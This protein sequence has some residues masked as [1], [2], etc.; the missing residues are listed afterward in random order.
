MK[1]DTAVASGILNCDKCQLATLRSGS[2]VPA[3]PGANYQKG[4]IA[5]YLDGP[6]AAAEKAGKPLTDRLGRMVDVMLQAAGLKREDVLVLYRV[7]CRAPRNR[8][9]DYPDAVLACDD[10]L[11]KEIE[12]Y[13]PRVIVTCGANASKGIVSG[14]N[15]ISA[16]R[17]SVRTARGNMG[18]CTDYIFT[19]NP[20]A[21]MIA[22]G[23]GTQMCNE[24]VDDLR[25]SKEL[26]DG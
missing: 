5:I 6:D 23:I 25:L 9:A 1:Q 16:I 12:V 24:F 26:R 3:M 22:G 15:G 18:S 7:R 4:G 10:W 11:K 2:A 19:W 20:T 8:I 17:G 21:I 14:T 13:E